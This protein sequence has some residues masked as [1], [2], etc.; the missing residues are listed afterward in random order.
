MSRG[1]GIVIVGGGPAGHAAARGYREAGGT[2]PVRLVTNDDRPPYNRP[3]L[4][5]EFLRGETG[6]DE[7]PLDPVDGVEIVY[8]HAARLDVDARMVELEDGRRLAYSSCCLATGAEP[9][10]LPLDGAEHERVFVVRS[11]LDSKR[12]AA[13]VA[14]G[15]RVVVLGTGFIGC[16]AAASL[17]MRG[18]SVVVVGEEEVPQEA[19][20]G[21]A[22][23]RRIAGFLAELGIELRTGSVEAIE[24]GPGASRVHHGDGAPVEAA[25]VVMATGVRP[26]VELAEAAGLRL[27][28]GGRAI[29]ADAAL[30]TTADHVFAAGDVCEAQHPV[31]GRPLRVEHWGD[32]LAQGQVAGRRM[33]GDT[34]AVWDG[35]PGFWSTIGR[36]TLKY[37][38]WG[39]GFADARLVEHGSGAWT[40]WYAGDDG[41]CV[42][43]LCHERDEDYERGSERIAAQ[44]PPPA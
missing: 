25:V 30:R 11:V 1:E 9:A 10:R 28:E 20:L 13:A 35:V 5:K 21:P 44:E 33:A 15:T 3:P 22:A 8:G 29:A 37:A 2:A 32:A 24:H 27:G 41:A 4:T 18:A 12:L 7:L 36:H 6:E 16:E 34:E 23:G 26:R 19:R 40:V 38:A 39:D 17:A 43:V 31:A 14:P 42:G